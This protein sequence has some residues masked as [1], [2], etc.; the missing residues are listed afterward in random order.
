M[1]VRSLR[2]FSKLN[3]PSLL[4]DWPF[5]RQVVPLFSRWARLD[6]GTF[7]LRERSVVRVRVFLTSKQN[8]HVEWFAGPH[9]AINVAHKL[10]SL[11][12]HDTRWPGWIEQCSRLIMGQL[13]LFLVWESFD[14]VSLLSNGDWIMIVSARLQYF[15]PFISNNNVVFKVVSFD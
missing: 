7:R 12:P 14:N 4:L 10:L 8:R 11:L 5:S 13:P 15:G 1:S 9:N 2:E 6:L 3:H